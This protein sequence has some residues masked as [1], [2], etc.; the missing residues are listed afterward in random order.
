MA[1]RPRD[2]TDELILRDWLDRR[3]FLGPP[4]PPGPGREGLPPE[5]EEDGA[6][7]EARS[8]SD[9]AEDRPASRRERERSGFLGEVWDVFSRVEERRGRVWDFLSEG[10]GLWSS[11]WGVRV[12]WRS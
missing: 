4:P 3:G 9:L 8:W 2:G 10:G 1:A 7:V 6:A 12:R 11:P 5:V